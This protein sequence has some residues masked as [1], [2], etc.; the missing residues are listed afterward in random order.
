M[1]GC[2]ELLADE[3]ESCQTGAADGVPRRVVLW[4]D[5]DA[6]F[7]RLWPHVAAALAGRSVVPLVCQ[8]ALGDQLDLKLALLR[9][10][11]EPGTRTVVYLPGY[12]SQSLAPRPDGTPPD[13]WSVYE[14]RFKG[15]FWTLADEPQVGAIPSAPTLLGWLN[16]HSV[17]VADDATVARLTGGGSASLL[18]RYTELQRNRPPSEWPRPLKESEV[19]SALG[20]DPRDALRELIAAP[21]NAVRLW[22]ERTQLALAGIEAAFGLRCPG[23]DARPEEIADAFA[24]QLALTEAWDAFGRTADFPFRTRLPEGE[25]QRDRSVRFLRTDVLKDVELGP[26]Y[27]ERILRLEKN[28]DLSQWAECRSGQPRGLPLLARGRWNAFLARFDNLAEQDWRQARDLLL[29]A[30]QDIESGRNTPWDQPGGDTHWFVLDTA[31]A[32]AETCAKAVAEAVDLRGAGQ[33][34]KAYAERWWEADRLHLR[35]RAACSRISG[36]ERVRRVTDLV[37]FGYA[38]DLNDKLSAFVEEEGCWPPEGTQAVSSVS[39]R[40]WDVG[41]G[42]VGVVVSDALRWDL[43]KGLSEMLSVEMSPIIATLPT[44]TSFGMSALL[45]L[46]A[47]EIGVAFDGGVSLRSSDGPNLATRDG[48]K[49]FLATAVRRR[50]GKPGVGFLDLEDVLRG[51]R[52]PSTPF[53]VVFDNSIDEQGHKGTEELPGLAEQ[54]VLKLRRV[55]ERLHESGI[56]EVH[57]VTDHGFLLLP[58]DMVNGL[59]GPSVQVGQVWRRETRWCALKADAPVTGLARLPLGLGQQQVTLGFPRGVRTLIE[60]EDYI[61]GGI[62]L[63]EA[64]IPHMVS[65]PALRPSKLHV[66]VRVTTSDLVTGTVPVVLRPEPEGLFGQQPICI[67][68]WVERTAPPS[69]GGLVT[70]PVEVEVRADAEELKPPLY[71]K[72]GSD[73]RTGTQLVLR[74]MD[75]ANGRE[76]AAVPLRMSVDWD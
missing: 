25:E 41:S 24:L 44:I 6:E 13:L 10:E 76:L 46:A 22:S 71:L 52:I 9:L 73:I 7:L 70:E 29:G 19:I 47:A 66:E 53:V 37:Y 72:E 2:A 57:V 74:A 55:I 32:L 8:K 38:N 4:L 60:S 42:R 34:I 50:D 36:L 75:C 5:P 23:G 12:G 48:R 63:Q 14:Y 49:S 64:V 69:E 54:L 20:G 35:V 40:L 51:D 68:L 31:R 28:V 27:R 1:A 62:S 45:P 30:S 3:L 58:A 39:D 15:A 33:L 18:A 56:Q 26:R 59:G 43:A 21:S 65:R 61:H 17:R 67:R 16:G 11:T